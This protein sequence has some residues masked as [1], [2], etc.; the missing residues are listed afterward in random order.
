MASK[1]TGNMP[2]ET[3]QVGRKIDTMIGIKWYFIVLLCLFYFVCLYTYTAKCDLIR[4]GR[5]SHQ[6]QPKLV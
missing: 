1:M 2:K 6:Q 3:Q 5:G 4:L